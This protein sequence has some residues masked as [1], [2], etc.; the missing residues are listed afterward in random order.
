MKRKRWLIPVIA[1]SLLCVASTGLILQVQNG[2]TTISTFTSFGR[3]NC[4]TGM[5]CS[6]SGSTVT[7]TAAGTGLTS[8]TGDGVVL[9]STPS[10][11]GTATLANAAAGSVLNNATASAAAPT[12]TQTPS[13]GAVG[14]S[15]GS[16]TFLGSTSGTATVGCANATCT[17]LNVS[18]S[19]QGGKYAVNTN[20]SAVGTAANPSVAACT[21][22]PA[23]AFSCSTTGTT[24]QV[25]T[26]VVTANSDI[27]IEQTQ[28]TA[29][30]TRLSV[31]CN[32]TT[33]TVSPQVISQVAATSF[34]IQLT[35]PVTNPD[36]FYFWINN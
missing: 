3:L 1:I 34:T 12:Y 17:A 28:N 8:F 30:G 11:T 31:T 9:S 27:H 26:T 21:S 14:G 22:A 5:S 35:Q 23:G 6:A 10:G 19:V 29:V 20:C 7:M 36:C 16:I 4:S 25:N 13:V 15:T 18:T 33:S 2:G 32:T 24:C